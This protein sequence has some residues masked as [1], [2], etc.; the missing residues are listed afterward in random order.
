MPTVTLGDR[1]GTDYAGTE[2]AML[3]SGDANANFSA[4][5]ASGVNGPVLVRFTGLTSISGPV[6]V[7]DAYFTLYRVA[8][9][10][11]PNTGNI[12]R[13]LRAWVETQAS[14][15]NYITGNGWTTAGCA[16]ADNDRAS[17]VS[18]ELS[19]SGFETGDFSSTNN[20]TLIA[21]VEGIIN[22]TLSNNGWILPL[23]EGVSYGLP[24]NTTAAFRPLL[25]VTYTSSGGVSLP[26][27]VNANQPTL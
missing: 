22:G 19:Q 24:A 27:F 13:V 12:Y 17:A 11:G 6:T 4:E 8:G 25:T 23:F 16:S 1:S 7:S 5:A 2:D 20:T 18:A 26:L 3:Y 10:L 21:N 14:W 9:G 15:N